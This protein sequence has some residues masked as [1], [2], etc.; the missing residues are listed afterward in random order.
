M[1]EAVSAKQTSVRPSTLAGVWYPD[2]PEKLR[3]ELDVILNRGKTDPIR[4]PIR[5]LITPHAGYRFCGTIIAAAVRHLKKYVYRRIVVIGPSHDHEFKGLSLPKVDSFQTPLGD[6]K[7]DSEVLE[8]LGRHPLFQNSSTPHDREHSIEIILPFLQRTVG[9][10][11]TLVPILT[12]AMNKR[13]FADAAEAIRPWLGPEDLLVISGDLTHYG[14]DH[15]FIPF[16][17]DADVEERLKEL[18]QG[19]ISNI[20]NW[21]PEGLVAYVEKTGI[22]ACLLAPAILLLNLLNGQCVPFHFNY[23]TSYASNRKEE[24]SISYCSGLFVGPVPLCDGDGSRELRG[25]DLPTLKEMAKKCL[26]QVVLHNTHSVDVDKMTN[27]ELLPLS[28]R[29]KRGAFVNISKKKKPRCSFGSIA[30]VKPLFEVVLENTINAVRRDPNSTPIDKDEVF[31]LEVD[32]SALSSLSLVESVDQIEVGRHGIAIEKGRMHAGFLP[33]IIVDHGW[34]A[35]EALNNLAA[36]A[37]LPPDGWQAPEC[38]IM[39]FTTQSTMNR[40]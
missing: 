9:D 37:G 25:R 18:D 30:P 27:V 36:M 11:W 16:P 23:N 35:Q 38:R 24:N 40:G 10:G 34:T 13:E 17:A 8:A 19:A 33:H 2:E 22:N 12:G 1:S 6:I 3:R 15:G 21:D 5:A 32:V 28:L 14:P 31:D 7:L 4:L 26:N 20:L 39:V 29:Q